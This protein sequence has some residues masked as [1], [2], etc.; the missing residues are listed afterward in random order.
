MVKKT[1]VIALAAMVV[2]VLGGCSEPPPPQPHEEIVQQSPEM[3]T[4]TLAPAQ[5]VAV[6]E[7]LAMDPI[8]LPQGYAGVA[9]IGDTL[10]LH[11]LG[12]ND[13]RL[14]AFE[15]GQITYEVTTRDSRKMYTFAGDDRWLVWGESRGTWSIWAWNKED[16]ET[17]L[18]SQADE[19]AIEL[20]APVFSEI[21]IRFSSGQ[22]MWASYDATEAGLRTR[23]HLFDLDSSTD[24]ILLSES[25]EDRRWFDCDL[26]KDR[27]ACLQPDGIHVLDGSSESVV[28]VGPSA[29]GVLLT[30]NALLWAEGWTRLFAHM[31]GK[32][33]EL[34]PSRSARWEFST[35][36]DYVA[37]FEEQSTAVRLLRSSDLTEFIGAEAIQG[38]HVMGSYLLWTSRGSDRDQIVAWAAKLP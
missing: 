35:T 38:S 16:K 36:D 28:P 9:A 3:E 19:R 26:F 23:L 34:T 13:G 2:M 17:R 8:P 5:K 33:T 11:G 15:D 37:W 30:A 27:I 4:A 22:L 20:G 6:P 7:K 25:F 10:I 32:T 29:G 14:V 31:D 24:T 21:G 1:R 12:E 18:I